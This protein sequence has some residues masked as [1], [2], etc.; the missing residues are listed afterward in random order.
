MDLLISTLTASS[1]ILPWAGSVSLL[2]PENYYFSTS[3][4]SAGHMV[5]NCSLFSALQTLTKLYY[6][7]K[8]ASFDEWCK[9][10]EKHKHSQWTQHTQQL[11]AFPHFHIKLCKHEG[12]ERFAR[13]MCTVHRKASTRSWKQLLA[14][15]GQSWSTILFM[16]SLDGCFQHSYCWLEGVFTDSFPQTQ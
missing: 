15:G 14:R 13:S 4:N 16:A 10:C 3:T 2:K 6:K 8:A 7:Y 11:W 9:N 5:R 12:H 1:E